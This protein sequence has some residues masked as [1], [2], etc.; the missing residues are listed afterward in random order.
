MLKNISF[1]VKADNKIAV[2]SDNGKED[3]AARQVLSHPWRSGEGY[4]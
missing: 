3:S 4:V 1:S 2:L